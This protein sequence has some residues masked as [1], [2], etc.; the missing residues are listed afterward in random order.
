MSNQPVKI[1]HLWNV[2]TL[3]SDYAST[4]G[5]LTFASQET[6]T[7]GV[8]AYGISICMPGD[9]FIKSVGIQHATDRLNSQLN[10]K[11]NG[12]SSYFVYKGTKRYIDLK[13]MML[14]SSLADLTH[15]SNTSSVYPTL[16]KW[17]IRTIKNE[18]SYIYD[19]SFVAVD[20]CI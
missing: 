20:L 8:F 11:E 14:I 15:K 2:E 16:P 10:Q 3:H 4:N 5:V 17:A 13:F 6:S 7:P 18:L 12:L 9:Q 1:H 19:E